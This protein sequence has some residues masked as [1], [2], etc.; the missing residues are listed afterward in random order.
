MLLKQLG[1]SG[2]T[3]WKGRCVVYFYVQHSEGG[4]PCLCRLRPASVGPF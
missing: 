3:G 1:E 4:S 2:E